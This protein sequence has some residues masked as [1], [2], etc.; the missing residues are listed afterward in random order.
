MWATAGTAE[1]GLLESSFGG[2]WRSGGNFSRER[3]SLSLSFPARRL[4]KA[5]IENVDDEQIVVSAEQCG[6]HEVQNWPNSPNKHKTW[7]CFTQLI[8]QN[9]F[10]SSTIM[11]SSFNSAQTASSTA[12]LFGSLDSV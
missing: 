11:A 9:I 5:L 10:L 4:R 3:A 7:P 1:A 2:H 6:E 12:L 8:P